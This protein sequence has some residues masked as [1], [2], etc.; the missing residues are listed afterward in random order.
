[1]L[2]EFNVAN[3]RSIK[4]KQTLSLIAA[5]I[6][7]RDKVD[8]NNVIELLDGHK[9]LKS[10]AIYGA[11]GSGKSNLIRALLR[12]MRFIERA[13]QDAEEGNT[14]EPFLLDEKYVKKPIHF[15][16]V[17]YIRTKRYRYG[18]EVTNEKITAEWLFGPA[19]KNEVEYFTRLAKKVEVNKASFKEGVGLDT[20]NLQDSVLFLNVVSALGGTI[21]SEIKRYFRES[22]VIT[23]GINDRGFL[24][25]SRGMLKDPKMR[26][27][28]MQL[29]K[30]A[31]TGI[32]DVRSVNSEEMVIGKGGFPSEIQK[33]I[34]QGEKIDFLVSF[35]EIK[36]R[37]HKDLSRVFLFHAFESEGTKRLFAYAGPIMESLISGS[38]LVIDEF[39]ARLH[40]SLTRKIIE[41]F[42][43]TEYNP[44]NAQLI[45]VTHDITLLDST[46]L[47]RDQIYF[48]EKGS[49]GETSI[50]SLLNIGGVRN[51]ASFE[52]D[53]IRGKYGAV[54]YLGNFNSLLK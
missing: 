45:F 29:L 52:K 46:L 8:E 4:E 21:S 25:I 54:P 7:S 50:Y 51:D 53:Y 26:P 37:E 5:P 34:E 3:F 38:A 2:A 17:F 1:M 24:S 10:V 12:M 23:S 31:D 49:A 40:P 16:L 13:F 44:K 35:R 9:L 20:G 30:A 47:R 32:S 43:S 36:N 28:I 33:R 6:S 11:N 48:T 42:N 27:R 19:R 41:L 39:D 18:F 14:L 15:E 22:I